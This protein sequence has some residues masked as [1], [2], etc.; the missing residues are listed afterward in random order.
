MVEQAPQ[1]TSS[2]V[3]IGLYEEMQREL[4]IRLKQKEKELK[5]LLAELQATRNLLEEAE[6]DR[7]EEEESLASAREKRESLETE[8]E[9]LEEVTKNVTSELINQNQIPY[10]TIS[11]Q[12]LAMATSYD[13]R[14]NLYTLLYKTSW[15]SEDANTFFAISDAH[16]M[17]NE[18][19]FNPLVRE[20]LNQTYNVIQQVV[21]K[22][23]DQIKA[24]YQPTLTRPSDVNLEQTISSIKLPSSSSNTQNSM[25]KPSEKTNYTPST[26]KILE[27]VKKK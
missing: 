8:I 12:E 16:R 7:E 22:R 13:A 21:Q 5:T 24:T 11:Q 4:M 20:N 9:S 6:H 15:T 25:Y 17:A 10:K 26:P 1:K 18:Y 14:N 3:R 27:I 19:D 2:Q 23:E